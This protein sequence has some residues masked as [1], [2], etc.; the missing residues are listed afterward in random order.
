MLYKMQNTIENPSQLNVT[1]KK[2][3]PSWRMHN[4]EEL[5]N[6]KFDVEREINILHE[7]FEKSKKSY[8]LNSAN[9]LDIYKVFAKHRLNIEFVGTTF[10]E[11]QT[12][13]LK[14]IDE[15]LLKLCDH[16]WIHDVIDEPLE[17]SR[18]ICYC[19]KCYCRQP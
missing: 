2:D 18:N 4:I 3:T 17:R 12:E 14:N 16:N 1:S 7:T 10:L 15:I 9:D 13:L 8:L 11:K 6:L 5:I 19:G